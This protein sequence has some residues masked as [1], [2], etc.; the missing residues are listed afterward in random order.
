MLEDIVFW[1]IHHIQYV[2]P[3]VALAQ[4]V[5]VS[6]V[7]ALTFLSKA[8]DYILSAGKPLVNGKHHR[9]ISNQVSM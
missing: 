1:C 2:C 9:H 3:L 6:A 7:P 5:T 8:L 4:S